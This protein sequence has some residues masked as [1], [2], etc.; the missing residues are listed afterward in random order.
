MNYYPDRVF[1]ETPQAPIG[2]DDVPVGPDLYT[3]ASAYI[4]AMV[5]RINLLSDHA[6]NYELGATEGIE[7]DDTIRIDLSGGEIKITAIQI[8]TEF[9]VDTPTL[10]TLNITGD[11]IVSNDLLIDGDIAVTGTVSQD[12]VARDIHTL[13]QAAE[14]GDPADNQ[15]V[16]WN[17]NG[18]GYGDAGDFCCK[19][20]EGGGTT[21]F[22]ISDYSTL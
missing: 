5:T 15:A 11:L 7:W 17:S 8:N 6:G 18:T 20:T 13:T 1:P 2:H 16:F 22:T 21:D 12:Y 9:V 14:P 3:M 4:P 10:T 19:I